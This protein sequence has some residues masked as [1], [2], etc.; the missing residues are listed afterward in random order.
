MS[1]G[2][3][4]GRYVLIDGVRTPKADA[5]KQKKT[6]KTKPVTTGGDVNEVQEKTTA[7]Q[8]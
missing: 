6:K 1:V 8:T 7:S 4:G 3:K 2:N 5:D